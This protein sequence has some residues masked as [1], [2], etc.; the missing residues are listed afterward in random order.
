MSTPS[1]SHDGKWLYFQSG[2][3]QAGATRI[4]R[5]PV[6]G[7]E[8]IAASQDPGA[9]PAESYDQ[10]TLY[11]VNGG[12]VSTINTT[13]RKSESTVIALAGMPAVS[14]QSLWTVVPNG[15]YFAPMESP[16]SVEYF[17][18]ATKHVRRIC[19]FEKNFNNGLSVSPDGR[20]LLYT[21]VDKANSDIMLV[22]NFR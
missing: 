2:A 6:N 17:D 5:C 22:E 11:F 21:Q 20:W 14:D 10:E 4:F 18:F 13:P 15:I 7:G 8:A 1:W 19:K 12:R 3:S 16:K 9:Y